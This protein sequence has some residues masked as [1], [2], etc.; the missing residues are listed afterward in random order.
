VESYF[1]EK[2]I[3]Y[4]C[5]D[6]RHNPTVRR[7]WRERYGGEIVPTVV[8]D[9]GR[10]VVDGCDLPAI[11]RIIQELAAPPSPTPP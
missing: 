11:K 2:G 9:G 5:K 3:P 7:E 6:I 4:T 1:T 10:R 8:F